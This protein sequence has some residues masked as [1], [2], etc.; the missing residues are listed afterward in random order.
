[1]VHLKTISG[2]AKS[3]ETPTVDRSA[4]SI[5]EGQFAR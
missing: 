5:A 1:M 4:L 2:S 3:I